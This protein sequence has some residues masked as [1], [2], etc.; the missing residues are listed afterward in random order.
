METFSDFN[1]ELFRRF[2]DTRN[3]RVSAN[4]LKCERL[5]LENK[6]NSKKGL[7]YYFKCFYNL[8]WSPQQF[9]GAQGTIVRPYNQE[10]QGFL[11]ISKLFLF[12][13]LVSYRPAKR[14][15]RRE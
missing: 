8:F 2:A 13:G 14:L 6:V 11:T 7:F 9:W 5:K 4:N 3:A 15:Y 10:K 12:W 1:N